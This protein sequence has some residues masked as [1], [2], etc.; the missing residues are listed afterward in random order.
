M[1]AGGLAEKLVADK[2]MDYMLRYKT[3]H[4]CFGT[5]HSINSSVY[6]G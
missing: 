4:S 1:V 5:R 3:G 2:V 6:D